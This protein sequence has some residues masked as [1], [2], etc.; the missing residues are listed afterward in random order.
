MKDKS[1]FEKCAAHE[2]T[3]AKNHRKAAA[4]TTGATSEFHKSM[5]DAHT[6]HADYFVACAK[7]CASNDDS[8]SGVHVGTEMGGDDPRGPSNKAMPSF[9]MRAALAVEKG[10][11]AFGMT[12]ARRDLDKIAPTEVHGVVSSQRE[13]IPRVGG[14]SSPSVIDPTSAIDQLR[15]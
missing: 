11:P 9:G 8:I 1:H 15:K 6:A 5:Q 13:F 12:A 10:T 4:E 7:A 14:P 2:I 3:C